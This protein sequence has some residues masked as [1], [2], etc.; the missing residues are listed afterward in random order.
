MVQIRLAH[1][2]EASA[3]AAL[4]LDT[5]RQTF[6]DEGFGIPY[7]PADLAAFEA[8]SYSAAAIAA[9][10]ADPERRSWVAEDWDGRLLGYAQVGPC[11]L[12]HPEA[13]PAQGELYQLYILR[14]AQGQKLGKQ[15]LDVTLDY[16]AEARP[17]P[18]WLGVW[19]GNDK[20][21]AV[22]AARGFERVGDYRFKVGSWYDEEHIYRK[23]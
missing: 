20:A 2:E 5:F 4:K 16:L 8:D 10:L 17:G 23:R 11:K 22:Y 15:L 3:L 1:V 9:E 19:S 18:V 21:Q 14:E 12:P 6:L 7:P 13:G